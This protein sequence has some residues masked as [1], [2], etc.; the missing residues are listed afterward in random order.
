[1]IKRQLGAKAITSILDMKGLGRR[2]QVRPSGWQ[3]RGVWL[4][5]VALLTC[6]HG[7]LFTAIKINYLGA[8]R[9]SR[10]IM[11]YLDVTQALRTRA[12]KKAIAWV[13]WEVGKKQR[14]NVAHC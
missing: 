7:L 6:E 2:R 4:C 14:S 10:S 3:A 13:N 8:Q 11:P 9:G 12:I 5:K 1:M